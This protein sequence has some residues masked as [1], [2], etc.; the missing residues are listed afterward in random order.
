[1]R[2]AP[3]P[4]H[5][6]L[7]Q[8]ADS[9]RQADIVHA[10]RVVAEALRRDFAI[11]EPRLAVAGLNPHAGEDGALGDEERRIIAPA[12]AALAAEGWQVSGPWPA[13]SLFHEAARERYDAVLTMYHDQALIPL[14]T[15]DFY[16]GVNTTLG[17]GIVR[18]SPDHGTAFDIA[19]RAIAHRGSLVA[20]LR[21]AADMAR[22][23]AA[24]PAPA[25]AP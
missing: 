20:A 3:V 6:A 25:A 16:G 1:L 17:I 14:K 18:T 24:Q 7:R 23:R 19:G 2:V 10:G 8:V 11:A 15:L 9:L 13:D 12:V 22:A 4:I 5:L 21:L